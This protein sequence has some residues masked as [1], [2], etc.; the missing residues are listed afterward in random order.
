MK[1]SHDSSMWDIHDKKIWRRIF[2]YFS[3]YG[4]LTQSTAISSSSSSSTSACCIIIS[5]TIVRWFEFY[6]FHAIFIQMNEFMQHMPYDKECFLFWTMDEKLNL[7]LKRI[8]LSRYQGINL[9]YRSS[10]FQF[11]SC[12]K[13]LFDL[14]M[15]SFL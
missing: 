8:F 7:H 6:G 15:T 1:L 12:N 2:E 13:L 10:L 3:G 11:V 14:N 5:K 9:P 4:K